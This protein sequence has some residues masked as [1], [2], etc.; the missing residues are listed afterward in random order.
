MFQHKAKIIRNKKIAGG[1]FHCVLQSPAVA[2]Q[3]VPGQFVSIKLSG[4]D[5]ALLLR[6][7]FSI[8]RANNKNI[9]ILYALAGKGTEFFSRRKA[10]EFLDLIGPLGKGF[11][12]GKE[13][14]GI[15][16]L[17]AGGIGVAPLAFLAE[18][19]SRIKKE[20]AKREIIILIGAKSK[21]QV[22][23][24]KEF[25]RLG[26]K[27]EVSTDDGSKGFKGTAA[28][29]LES[30]LRGRK[31]AGKQAIF[32][33]GPKP[34]LKE[35]GGISRQYGI[36]AQLSLEEHMAC[37]FGACLGCVVDTRDGYRRVCKDG[38]VFSAEEIIWR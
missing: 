30:I 18:R 11:D 28:D 3:A 34:M 17:V 26:C 20:K 35:V 8:H 24:E 36:P 7:P 5:A 1:F 13:E 10:G 33:C 37:G 4:E 12:Y 16:I 23:C 29:L 27:V 14:G 15:V 38:P 22:F 19:L 9:E 6:R 2:K 21:K 25:R 32:A 31:F